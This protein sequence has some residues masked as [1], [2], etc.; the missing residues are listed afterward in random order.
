MRTPTLT[1]SADLISFA[2]A[3]IVATIA[4]SRALAAPR[5]DDL[6]LRGLQL[7]GKT[8]ITLSGA[9]LLPEPRLLLGDEVLKTALRDGATAE[10]VEVEVDLPAESFPGIR[11]LRV[12]NS[13]GI[14]NAIAIVVDDLPQSPASGDAV[15]IPSAITGRCDGATRVMTTFEA[16]AGSTL[17]IEIEAKR[18]GS[19]LNPVI[20]LLDDSGAQLAW[21]QGSSQ[22]DGDVR[23]VATLPRDGRYQVEL[24]DALFQGQPPAFFRL[25][26]TQ[27]AAPVVPFLRSLSAE[28]VQARSLTSLLGDHVNVAAWHPIRTRQPSAAP[29]GLLR[30]YV[31]PW[32]EVVEETDAELAG[33]LSVPVGINGRLASPGETDAYQIAVKPGA[34]LKIDCYAERANSLLDGVLT[35]RG[36]DGATLANADDQRGTVDPGLEFDVPA[37]VNIISLSLKDLRHRGGD[38]FRYRLAITPAD[39]PDFRV[40][41][42]A[43]RYLVPIGGAAV[44]RAHV[45][46]V[47]YHGPI[48]LAFY[49]LPGG[50]TVNNPVIPA[51]AN[52][53]LITL[54]GGDAGQAAVV[55]ATAL[56]SEVSEPLVRAVTGPANAVTGFSPWLGNEF[57]VATTPAAPVAIAWDAPS[58]GDALTLASVS[59]L[60]AKIS[61]GD[62]VSGPVRISLVTNQVPPTKNENNRQVPDVERTLRLAQDTVAPAE[63]MT[64]AVSIVVPADLAEQPYDLAMKAELLSADGSQVLATSY[65]ATRRLPVKR[66]TF[67]LRLT[68]GA[69]IAVAADG[70]LAVELRGTLER[71]PGFTRPV[72]VKLE[73]APTPSAVTIG[74]GQNEFTLTATLPPALP[75]AELRNLK[76]VALSELAP[77]IIVPAANEI[78]F[79]VRL[80]AGE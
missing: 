60:S 22:L 52:D 7:G 19:L 25:K 58:D 78:P 70:Q 33:V 2:I 75:L 76:L 50:V 4:S 67:A 8:T 79:T 26:L 11:Q 44:I 15:A 30:M 51:G 65:S 3:L 73:G 71:G 54:Q 53:A 9:E 21:A 34:K 27:Q 61:R 38:D 72:T 16:A 40:T 47:G 14:S 74:E 35:I 23:L 43:D 1:C 63:A 66:P 55:R 80:E 17:A 10:R 5:I 36:P 45:D 31:S 62:G 68:G 57:A 46:R 37:G 39:Q 28:E 18:L 49:G 64:S 32:R 20:H 41:F 59:T 48:A 6:S 13:L 77:Q 29:T 42:D 56:A 24:H 69:T 12:A